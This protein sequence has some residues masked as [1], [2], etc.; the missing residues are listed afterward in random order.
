MIR[1]GAQVQLDFLTREQ[2]RQ[3]I[4]NAPNFE[5]LPDLEEVRTVT[6]DGCSPIPCGGT[7]IANI[8]EIGTLS[9]LRAEDMHDGTFRLHFSVSD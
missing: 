1:D 6:I 7:H 5:R 3:S 4:E 8:K 9:D 2:A